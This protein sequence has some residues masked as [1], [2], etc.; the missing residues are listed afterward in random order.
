MLVTRSLQSEPRI[1]GEN[2]DFGGDFRKVFP[3]VTKANRVDIITG[4]TFWSYYNIQYLITNLRLMHS[5]LSNDEHGW[6][7]SFTEWT[8][9]VNNGHEQGT[10]F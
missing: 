3:V 10:H 5:N 6:L 4:A 8:L 1:W 7:R 2:G 9:N